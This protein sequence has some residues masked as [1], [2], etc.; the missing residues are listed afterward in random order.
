MA[1]PEKITEDLEE[2]E[3]ELDEDELDEDVVEDTEDEK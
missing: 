2:S 3:V 1:K